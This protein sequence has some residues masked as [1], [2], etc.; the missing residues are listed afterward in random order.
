MSRL[1]PALVGLALIITFGIAEGLWANRWQTSDAPQRAA[2]RL[3][4]VPLS[5]GDWQSEAHELDPRQVAKAELT[6][7]LYRRYVHERTR[8]AVTILLVCGPPGPVSVHTPDV[9]YQGAGYH[10]SEPQ[11]RH[12]VPRENQPEPV[13]CWIGQFQ[14]DGAVPDPLRIFWVWGVKGRWEAPDNPRLTF[15][16]T[17]A[18][19]KLYAIR[20]LP[21]SDEPLDKD[22]A[23][24]LLK[25]LL[26]QLQDRLFPDMH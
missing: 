18:L 17:G 20:D 2:G 21:R 6:G 23:L 9:C 26:P 11:A 3:A 10:L 1:L 12:E 4:E 15:A 19:Y 16:R 24:D 25:V 22:A 5:V 13:K 14:K 8:E 7:Y